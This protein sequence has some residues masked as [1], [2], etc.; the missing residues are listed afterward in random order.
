MR[1][2]P[3][4]VAFTER[5]FRSWEKLDAERML[6]AFGRDDATLMIESDPEEW[7]NGFDLISTVVR[8]PDGGVPRNGRR[9]FRC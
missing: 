2:A 7:W 3:E 9:P 6:D 8:V 5:V 4:L 1:A